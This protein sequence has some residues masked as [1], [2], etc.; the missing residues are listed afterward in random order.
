MSTPA[1]VHSP[2]RRSIPTDEELMDLPKDGY[3]RELLHGEMVMSPGGFEHGRQITRFSVALGIFVYQHK[4][5]EI[6]DG[7]T[8]IRRSRFS[9]CRFGG[10]CGDVAG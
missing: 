4:L 10:V 8:G 1:S 6:F 5:G 9:D 2:S 7:Q 3:K